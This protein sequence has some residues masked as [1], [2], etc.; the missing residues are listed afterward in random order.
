MTSHDRSGISRE[1][2][3]QPRWQQQ[4]QRPLLDLPARLLQRCEVHARVYFS[5]ITSGV[6]C[7][8]KL[9]YALRQTHILMTCTCNCSMLAHFTIYM[10]LLHANSAPACT[11]SGSPHNVLHSPSW[12]ERERAPHRR[13]QC[14]F[15]FYIYIYIYI[16]IILY[17]Y[18]TSCRKS[19]P[20]RILRV[21]ASCVISKLSSLPA[22][23]LISSN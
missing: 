7:V 4:R 20:A 15:S 23:A 2:G 8:L 16:Y 17:I 21:L 19:L 6:I 13:V 3:S 22:R 11:R 18:R 9:C 10:Q 12:G 1:R 5:V 14:E